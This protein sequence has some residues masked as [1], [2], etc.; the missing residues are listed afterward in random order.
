MKLSLTVVCQILTFNH[1][2][3]CHLQMH[4]NDSN[5]SENATANLRIPSEGQDQ[6]HRCRKYA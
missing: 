6:G 3:L 5:H 1:I 4:C 2:M